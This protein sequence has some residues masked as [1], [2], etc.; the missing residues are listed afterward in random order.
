MRVKLIRLFAFL[1]LL[2]SS[3]LS[4]ASVKHTIGSSAPHIK[5]SNTHYHLQ[6]DLSPS[7]H[8]LME[9]DTDELD[10]SETENDSIAKASVDNTFFY[11]IDI[12]KTSGMSSFSFRTY[13]PVHRFRYIFLNV[14]RL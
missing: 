2:Y 12:Y 14:F 9:M 6:S 13:I 3:A 10:D 4:A 5:L 7:E 1:L 11:S 8:L